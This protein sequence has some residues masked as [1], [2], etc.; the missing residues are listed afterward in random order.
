MT[1]LR[2]LY[3]FYLYRMGVLPKKRKPNP[4]RVYFLFREDIRFI[5]NISRETRLLVEHGIDTAEQL[6]DHKD[7][8]TAQINT[9]YTQRKKLRNQIRNIRD[10]VKLEAVKSEIAA[11]SETLKNLRR[12]VRLCEDIDRRSTEIRDKIRR[13]R[14]DEK[15]NGKERTSHEPFRG[16]R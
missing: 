5:Q 1:G 8:L 7:G 13:A 3:F 15:S 16:R 12:E 9:F 14:E 6:T 11:L 10:E 4:K 2:A